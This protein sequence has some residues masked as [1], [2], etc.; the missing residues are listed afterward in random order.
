VKGALQMENGLSIYPG[1]DNTLEEN[2]A[3]IEDAHRLGLKRLFTS[4]HIPETDS[5]ALKRE[6]GTLLHAAHDAGLE[7]ISDIS[8]AT[9]QLLGIKEF[10]ISAF[11]MLGITTLRLDYGF[12]LEEIAH[13]SRHPHG[14]RLQLNASTITGHILS[15]LVELKTDFSVIDA[16]H[17]FYPRVG[18][19]LSE[20]ALVRKNVMLHKLGIKVGAFVPS[21]QGRKRSPLRD[22]LPTLEDHRTE[23][24]DIAARH[25]VALGTDYVL[26]SDALPTHE[27]L[28]ALGDLA[29]DRVTLSARLLTKDAEVQQ[30]LAQPFTSRPDEARDA[31]RAQES[32]SKLRELGIEAVPENTIDRPV[33]AITLDNTGYGRY[34]GELQIIKEAQGADPRTNVVA[35]VDEEELGLLQY[36]TPGRKFSFRFHS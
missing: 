10:K 5:K 12:G 16:L 7:I 29:G 3:L 14:V 8:P 31:I 26:L 6:L 9:M 18:T 19:G 33:G 35:M 4:L 24:A 22:G 20:E 36:I 21:Q 2:L 11:R 17:N 28:A 15:A 13:M 30:F 32:R 1:L 23:A 25:L 27:E 34:M